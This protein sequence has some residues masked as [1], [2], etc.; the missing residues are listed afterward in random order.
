MHCKRFIR[1]GCRRSRIEADFAER[2]GIFGPVFRLVQLDI[3]R[4]DHLCPLLG[5]VGDEFAKLRRRTRE[6]DIAHLLKS[7]IHFGIGEPALISLLSFSMIS[8]RRGLRCAD[9]SLRS[10]ART[11]SPSVCRKCLHARRG[12]G[13]SERAQPTSV[14]VLNRSDSAAHMTCTCPPSRL[15]VFTF[16]FVFTRLRGLP[17]EIRPPSVRPRAK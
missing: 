14:D 8:A 15:V 10:P 1:P 5:F 16:L 17:C 6:H 7:R 3:G 13:Y 11:H 2:Y 9:A 12:G 4:P